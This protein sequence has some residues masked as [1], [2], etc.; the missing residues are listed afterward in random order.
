MRGEACLALRSIGG[1][2]RSGLRVESVKK[3]EAASA[4]ETRAKAHLVFCKRKFAALNGLHHRFRSTDH[5]IPITSHGWN[6]ALLQLRNQGA[7]IT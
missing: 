2:G 1:A 6:R 5:E 4:A 3:K 7:R